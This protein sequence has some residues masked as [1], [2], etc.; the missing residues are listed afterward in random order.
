MINIKNKKKAILFIIN[1]FNV[2][3]AE[4]FVLRLG[5]ALLKHYDVYVM[6]I[7][8]SQSNDN[9]KT[10]FQNVGIKFFPRFFKM[11]FLREKLYWKINA[12]YSF[13]G[14]KHVFNHLKNNFQKKQFNKL[15]KEKNI[16]LLHS[17]YYSSDTYTNN[18]LK[19]NNTLKWVLTMHGGYNQKVYQ[20]MD[21]VSKQTF[22]EN[23]IN[24]IKNCDA[25]TYVADVNLDFLNDFKV[26]PKKN[27]KIR[28]GLDKN[29]QNLPP[30]KK[31]DDEAFT[32]CMVA[33]SDRAKGWVEL[34][35]AFL[36]TYS[37]FPFIKVICVAPLEGVV[38]DLSDKYRG[39][40]EIIFTGY[41]DSPLNFIQKSDVCVLPTYFEGESSPYSIIEYLS[42][43]KP[44][45]ATRKGEIEDMLS[46]ENEVAGILLSIGDNGKPLISDLSNAMEKMITNQQ[47]YKGTKE[48]TSKVFK[49]FTM[50][51]CLNEYVK[52][53]NSL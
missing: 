20:E 29:E 36:I 11:T 19:D 37:K 10:K 13:F 16:F 49:K 30:Y 53:Y 4:L 32:F 9:F 33:R 23:A 6:D 45:I 17:H 42:C 14:K 12:F 27:K 34:L 7:F 52:L 48:V 5:K 44:V 39:R 50:D 15:V 46:H 28:L 2:G 51:N 21:E 38:K 47:F 26:K 22:V 24:N 3:G 18:L 25:M 31:H 43:S 35:E 41:T 8:P 1:D 40:N